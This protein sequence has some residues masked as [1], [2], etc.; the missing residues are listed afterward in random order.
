[1]S[2]P[3]V[4]SDWESLRI[5]FGSLAARF[6]AL[7]YIVCSF[8][9]DRFR[10]PP[11]LSWP[12]VFGHDLQPSSLMGFAAERGE[13]RFWFQGI[14]RHGD[15]SLVHGLVRGQDETWAFYDGCRALGGIA[16][17]AGELLLRS[18]SFSSIG[19]FDGPIEQSAEFRWLLCIYDILQP[20]RVPGV[21]EGTDYLNAVIPDVFRASGIACGRII[22]A[23]PRV[24]D[25]QTDEA[26]RIILTPDL[27]SDFDTRMVALVAQLG[28]NDSSNKFGT[29]DSGKK[30]G[31]LQPDNADV[32]DLCRLL[33]KNRNS[34]KKS[35]NQVARDFTGE[36]AGKDP[37]AQSLLRQA[38]RFRHLW[39]RADS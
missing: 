25:P 16:A 1:V 12:G 31:P 28:V 14:H 3:S 6:S 30:T 27:S 34:S 4:R 11:N 21:S 17:E 39:D 29:A 22:H 38:R 23:L 26:A 33:E 5:H 7:N 24:T 18:P 36:S 13:T 2:A 19:V 8:D 15:T 10:Y 32:R 35:L 37:K 20:A 9:A